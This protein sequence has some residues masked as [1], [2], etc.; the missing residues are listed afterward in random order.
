MLASWW[1]G[2]AAYGQHLWA[3][4]TGHVSVYGVIAALGLIALAAGVA[5]AI[6]QRVPQAWRMLAVGIVASLAPI[7]LAIANNILGWLGMLFAVLAGAI[8]LLVATW[9]VSIIADRR[10][11]VWLL[12]LFATAIM[13]CAAESAGA[14]VALTPP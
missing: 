4:L 1:G 10:L 9:S 12:G 14:F 13:I 5:M 7:A 11:P 2:I 6:R 8:I 3:L